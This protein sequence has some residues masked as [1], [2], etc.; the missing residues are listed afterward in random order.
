MQG[1]R[2]S[3]VFI[4][5]G[6]MPRWPLEGSAPLELFY[7]ILVIILWSRYNGQRSLA[8]QPASQPP[9]WASKGQTRASEHTHTHTHTQV[10]LLLLYYRWDY[11]GM[12]RLDSF[13]SQG[14]KCFENMTLVMILLWTSKEMLM[15]LK[16]PPFSF[17]LNNTLVKCKKNTT[18]HCKSF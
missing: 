5:A 12:E 7:S 2:Q 9:D 14:T 1:W 3:V 18:N 10:P 16:G 13:S 15:V 11:F 6:Q 17:S 8:G 4:I